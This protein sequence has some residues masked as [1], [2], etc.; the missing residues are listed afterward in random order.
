MANIKRLRVGAGM[1]SARC[2]PQMRLLTATE[3]A[4]LEQLL[5]IVQRMN[6]G[7]WAAEIALRLRSLQAVRGR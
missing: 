6:R 2:V 4:D 1:Y 5:R 3:L 7:E